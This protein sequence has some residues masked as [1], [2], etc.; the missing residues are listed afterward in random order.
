MYF[1]KKKNDCRIPEFIN[2]STIT[3]LV[4]V[5]KTHVLFKL[6]LDIQSIRLF[7]SWISNFTTQTWRIQLNRILYYVYIMLTQMKG[8]LN[9]L[10]LLFSRL[11]FKYFFKCLMYGNICKNFIWSAITLISLNFDRITFF[12]QHFLSNWC[13]F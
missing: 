4:I 11:I 7:S 10:Y 1:Q 12:S 8:K 13:P 2:I 3:Q 9:P 6:A 5:F